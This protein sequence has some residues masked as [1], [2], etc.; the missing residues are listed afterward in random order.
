MQIIKPGWKDWDKHPRPFTCSR[1]TC[2]FIAN[3]N[4]YRLDGIDNAYIICECPNC[5]NTNWAYKELLR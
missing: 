2:I 3:E 1:C 5:G 4:E